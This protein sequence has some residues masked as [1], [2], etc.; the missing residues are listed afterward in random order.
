[1]LSMM[2]QLR[3]AVLLM[4]E[5]LE[6]DLSPFPIALWELGWLSFPT[7]ALD[8]LLRTLELG[9]TKKNTQEASTTHSFKT[10]L[11]TKELDTPCGK[12]EVRLAV[13]S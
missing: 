12:Q 2:P 6:W 3:S 10:L 11:T 7:L 5:S 4:R 1:M 13:S 8:F 9:C